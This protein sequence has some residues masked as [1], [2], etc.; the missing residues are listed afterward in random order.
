MSTDT[1]CITYPNGTKIEYNLFK[2]PRFP[3]GQPIRY[4]PFC[5]S[6]VDSFRFDYH[7]IIFSADCSKSH[8]VDHEVAMFRD[9]QPDLRLKSDGIIRE[10]IPY[11]LQDIHWNLCTHLY[12]P[13][14]DEVVRPRVCSVVI[15]NT[16]LTQYKPISNRTLTRFKSQSG[17]FVD[18]E[19]FHDSRNLKSAVWAGIRY[20]KEISYY[21][22]LQKF[23]KQCYNVLPNALYDHVIQH[24][25]PELKLGLSPELLMENRTSA[26]IGKYLTRDTARKFQWLLKIKSLRKGKKVITIVNCNYESGIQSCFYVPVQKNHSHRI[27]QVIFC[28]VE[29]PQIVFFKTQKFQLSRFR[30]FGLNDFIY[31]YDDDD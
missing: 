8:L 12:A 13:D 21:R 4:L 1:V 19:L 5:V 17:D 7:K 16:L 27:A 29:N 24:Y 15:L 31:N 9:N 10:K 3:Q 20:A 28:L 14:E 23:R 25:I 30:K 18:N 11:W 26:D 2:D 22:S 6:S